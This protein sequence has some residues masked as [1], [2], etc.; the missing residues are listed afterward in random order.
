MAALINESSIL[1]QMKPLNRYVFVS[2]TDQNRFPD[3]VI[4]EN[5]EK[6]LSG[7]NISEL[8]G[9]RHITYSVVK[10]YKNNT[11]GVLVLALDVSENIR[12]F[13][14]SKILLIITFLLVFLIIAGIIIIVVNKIT[15]T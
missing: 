3:Y 7:N 10:D 5:I 14:H 1:S 4:E 2:S 8:R 15:F 6:A 13:T 11:L 9:N 12:K